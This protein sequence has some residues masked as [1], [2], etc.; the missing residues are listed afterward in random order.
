MGEAKNRR[1]LVDILLPYAA[2]GQLQAAFGTAMEGKPPL[3]LAEFAS[4]E[5]NFQS[6]LD[7]LKSGRIVQLTGV[8]NTT[9]TVESWLQSKSGPGVELLQALQLAHSDP[10]RGS[11]IYPMSFGDDMTLEID[12]A[13]FALR[14]DRWLRIR[15]LVGEERRVGDLNPGWTDRVIVLLLDRGYGM[16]TRFFF[17][18]RDDSPDANTDL[19]DEQI[20]HIARKYA[21]IK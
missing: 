7:R 10:N 14:H 18:C 1:K 15:P 13:F 2:E 17:G 5:P 11:E 16:R 4:G 21:R 9:H 19:T 8:R 20:I 3:A 12:R 6:I